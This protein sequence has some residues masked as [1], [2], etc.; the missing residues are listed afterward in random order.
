MQ[1]MLKLSDVNW[2]SKMG[3]GA[4]GTVYSSYDNNYA[5]KK[6]FFEETEHED[7]D[8]EDHECYNDKSIK[9]VSSIETLKSCPYVIKIKQNIFN[10]DSNG[11]FMERYHETLYDRIN[12]RGNEITPLDPNLALKWLYQLV[13]ASYYAAKSNIIHSDIKPVNILI[14]NN[15]NVI[16]AD[17]GHSQ[18]MNYG[19]NLYRP[20]IVQPL[21]YKAP[22]L[23]LNMRHY[24][25]KIDIWSIV[26]IY[27]EMLY[28][29]NIMGQKINVDGQQ[30]RKITAILGTPTNENWDE[31][32]SSITYQRYNQYNPNAN[33]KVSCPRFTS[34][35]SFNN[36]IFSMLQF[37]PKKRASHYEI[38]NN[39]VFHPWRPHIFNKPTISEKIESLVL[40]KPVYDDLK[41]LGRKRRV[42]IYWL[43]KIYSTLSLPFVSLVNAIVYFDKYLSEN[44][45]EDFH[46]VATSSI[47]LSQFLSINHIYIGDMVV[48]VDNKYSISEICDMSYKILSFFD[49]NLYIRSLHTYIK[50][51][52]DFIKSLNLN[53]NIEIESNYN[54]ILKVMMNPVYYLIDPASLCL[55]L[56]IHSN[57]EYSQ[58]LY[59]ISRTVYPQI[60]QTSY[61]IAI[62]FV[63]SNISSR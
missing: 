41:L 9:E 16:L 62:E 54:N 57:P 44:L 28:G 56:L 51:L 18:I 37:D 38:L 15:E 59:D 63:K 26:V 7:E 10:Y 14:D 19:Y 49:Y 29:F 52:L 33:K 32:E 45:L 58:S 27:L 25:E 21:P 22:E 13:V 11:Y 23:L 36:F 40:I 47:Y 39:K 2:D 35:E 34:D 50:Y 5:F 53:M 4:S 12:I 17:W 24:D 3:K 43:E 30:F 6:Y 60:T 61:D 31:I 8:E 42:V 48:I 55:A 1:N 46:L 20:E